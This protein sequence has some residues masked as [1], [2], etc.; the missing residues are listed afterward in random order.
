M[1]FKELYQYRYLLREIV[2]KNIKIQYRNSVL[3]MFWTLLQPFLTTLV[4]V[5]IFSGLFGGGSDPEIVNYPIYLLCGRLLYEFYSQATKRSMRSVT[6]SASVIKKVKVPKYIY[7]ISNTISTF[8]TF[9]I[10]LLV[11]VGFTLF[12]VFNPSEKN[13]APVLSWNILLAPVPLLILFLLCTGVGLILAT[14]SVFFKDIEYLYDVFTLLLFYATPIFYTPNRLGDSRALHMALMANPLYSIVEMFRDCVLR[15][16]NALHT[17][18][19]FNP[20]HLW[21]SL[22]FS[23]V[24][25]LV[26]GLM[27]WRKQDKFILHI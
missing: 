22:G 20:N 8:I 27:F 2:A 21:Y 23:L 15:G 6:L 1:F 3:G 4:L 9:L 24:M 17:G 19:P 5:F 14:L 10:S 18:W 13:P 12:F 7:P 26:G 11:L 25:L 16:G